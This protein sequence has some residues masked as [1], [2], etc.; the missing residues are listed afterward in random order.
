MYP[1]NLLATLEIVLVYLLP[2]F[3]QVIVLVFLGLAGIALSPSSYVVVVVV[4]S[5]KIFISLTYSP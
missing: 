3:S 2:F 1:G 5:L 4:V